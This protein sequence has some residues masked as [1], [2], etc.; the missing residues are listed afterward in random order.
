M[1]VRSAELESAVN[2]IKLLILQRIP[3]EVE[4]WRRRRR[5]SPSRA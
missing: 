3:L 5:I 2:W 1:F 4:Q